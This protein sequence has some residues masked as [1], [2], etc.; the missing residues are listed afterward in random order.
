MNLPII[1]Q[2]DER[3][4]RKGRQS[5]RQHHRPRPRPP[6]TMRRGKG[7]VQ[8]DMH[9]IHTQ[10]AGPH[11]AHDG[12]K[13]RPIAVNIAARRMNRVRNP[14]HIAL[15]QAACVR[16]G[17]HHP[18]HIRPQPR[19]QSVKIDPPIR[20]RRNALHPESRKSRRRR[21]GPMR[22]LGHQHHRPIL[23]PRINRGA[24]AQQAA[25]LPMRAS[26]GR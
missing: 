16:V 17:D 18:R 20:V 11:L 4:R 23:A 9:R 21:I 22:A 19:R 13:I 10:V 26:L 1:L 24:N 2:L 12:V 25:Q 7:L 5:R 6:A 8:I 15:K 14:L 3:Q